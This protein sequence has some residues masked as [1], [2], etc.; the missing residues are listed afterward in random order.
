MRVV[1]RDPRRGHVMHGVH[2]TYGTVAILDPE[3]PGDVLT[4]E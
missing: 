1:R 3:T 4:E 2:T